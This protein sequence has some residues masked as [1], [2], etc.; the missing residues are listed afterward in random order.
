MHNIVCFVTN[1]QGRQSVARRAAAE[2][3]ET[4]RL[5]CV[6]VCLAGVTFSI[7]HSNI[8]HVGALGMVQPG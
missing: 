2:G 1:L 7:M 4:Q 5:V 8:K 3:P 6:C